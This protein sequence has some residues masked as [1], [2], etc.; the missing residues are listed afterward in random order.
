MLT[1]LIDTDSLKK[2]ILH[3][4]EDVKDPEI[5]VISVVDLGIITNIEVK[6]DRTV[7]IGMTPTFTACPAIEMM[8]TEIKKRAEKMEGVK[9]V[10]VKVDFSVQW[11]SNLITEKGKQQIK[12]FG[13]APPPK[14][15]GMID[16]EIISKAA[17]P[18]CNSSNTTMQTPFGPTLCRSIHYCFDC[19]Q[20]FEQFKPI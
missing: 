5:P 16:L 15:D 14:H 6:E 13:L 9:S 19:R 7:I 1:N 10:E 12:D 18:H 20:A 17:C 2:Q 3:A 11:N 4:L 8:K